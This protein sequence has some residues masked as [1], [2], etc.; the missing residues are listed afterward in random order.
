MAVTGYK[1]DLM[2]PVV[3]L[4]MSD[5]TSGRGVR[6]GAPLLARALEMFKVASVVHIVAKT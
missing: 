5:S 3:Y 1:T 6:I 2:L 4:H